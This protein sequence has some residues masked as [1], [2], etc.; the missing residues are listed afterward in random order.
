ADYVVSENLE[1]LVPLQR[2]AP[3]TFAKLGDA[4]SVVRAS[5][6]VRG[7]GV[8]LMG[9]PSSSLTQV[10]GWRAR[11][12]AA[13]F[14]S[15]G[16]STRLRGLDVTSRRFSLPMIVHGGPVT[17]TL[18]V[19][20]PR[21]DFAAVQIGTATPGTHVLHAAVPAGRIVA[22]RLSLPVVAAFL[23][24]HRESGTTLSVANASRGVLKLGA[25]F[26]H[27]IG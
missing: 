27:W 26:S 6:D 15:L 5:G 1:R 3:A 20:K 7:R 25:P 10:G 2:V 24:G 22:L 14:A 21:G 18:E 19:L 11:P 12:S 16:P 4:V 9:L 8:T 13:T 23:A 17:L